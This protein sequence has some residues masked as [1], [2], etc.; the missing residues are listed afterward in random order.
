M[1][2]DGKMLCYFDGKPWALLLVSG[3]MNLEINGK[4]FGKNCLL[5]LLGEAK[6][7]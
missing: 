4:E 7:L 2:T 1:I 5:I 6:A 3:Y